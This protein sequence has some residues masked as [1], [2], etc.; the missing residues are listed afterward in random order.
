MKKSKKNKKNKNKQKQSI[1]DTQ[2]KE[3]I[4]PS[5]KP[6]KEVIAKKLKSDQLEEKFQK[7]LKNRNYN[8]HVVPRDGNCLFSSISDQ[9]YGT[10]KN[11]SIIREKC[12]DYIQKNSLFYSQFIEGGEKQMNAY[13]ERKRKAGIWADNLEIQALSEIY[14]RPIEIY[15]NTD[16]PIKSYSNIGSFKNRFPIKISYHGNNHYNSMVPDE[17][18]YEYYLYKKEL[19]LS[20]PGEYENDFIQKFDPN[21]KFKDIFDNFNNNDID[22]DACVEEYISKDEEFLINEAIENSKINMINDINNNEKDKQEN[23]EVY[24]NNPMIQN[25]LEFGFDLTEAIESLKI[26][27]PN[28]DLMLN[29]LYDKKN[30][31]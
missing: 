1:N 25:A 4:K 31:L 5:N 19:I 12:M 2:L 6:S 24:L 22:L 18:N 29:Y 17:I 30:S 26:C 14:K 23:D 15:V 10:E 3:N 11:N 7:K 13:I 9:V 21:T 8:L 16:K 28:L 27:G 20:K